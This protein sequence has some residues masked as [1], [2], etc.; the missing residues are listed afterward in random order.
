MTPSAAATGSAVDLHGDR[1]RL[2]GRRPSRPTARPTMLGPAFEHPGRRGCTARPGRRSYVGRP[3]GVV[4]ALGVR[5]SAAAGPG[6]RGPGRR[7]RRS[8]SCRA[9]CRLSVSPV[10][11]A[12]NC[13]VP[14]SSAHPVRRSRLTGR[15]RRWPARRS[16]RRR[17]LG[18]AC[19]TRSSPADAVQLASL[20]VLRHQVPLQVVPASPSAH[21]RQVDHPVLVVLRRGTPGRRRPG[22]CPVSLVSVPLA[23]AASGLS[24]SRV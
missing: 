21:A 3:L 18:S 9:G 1:Q 24:G 22:H 14:C 13:V 12:W 8:R 7:C 6:R 11:P 23:A 4:L 15:H 2:L 20:Q 10:P 19:A 16:G 17:A 5:R